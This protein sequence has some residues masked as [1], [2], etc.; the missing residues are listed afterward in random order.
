LNARGRYSLTCGD[1]TWVADRPRLNLL[2]DADARREYRDVRGAAHR[3][4]Q[5][6]NSHA[7]LRVLVR[8][9]IALRLNYSM[10]E[11]APWR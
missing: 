1:Y 5:E 8:T 3:T 2:R 11:Q 7:T 6:K 4:P 9:N 10:L